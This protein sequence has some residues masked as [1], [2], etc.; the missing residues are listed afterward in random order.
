MR[1]DTLNAS[2]HHLK[3]QQQLPEPFRKDPIVLL[4]TRQQLPLAGDINFVYLKRKTCGNRR[5]L[6][7]IRR[8]KITNLGPPIPS[9]VA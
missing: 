7:G 1:P 4:H 6:V 2:Q 8:A 5:F 3:H 9:F